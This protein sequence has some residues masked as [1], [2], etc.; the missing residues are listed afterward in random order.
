MRSVIKFIHELYIKRT[1]LCCILVAFAVLLIDYIT[2]RHIEFPIAYALPVGM[3]AWRQKRG[4]AYAMA[5]LLPMVRVGFYFPWNA[6]QFIYTALLNAPVTVLVLMIY[7]YL[8]DRTAWQTEELEKEI[9]ILE[10]ILPICASCKKIRNEAGEYE[11]I[12]KYVTEHSQASFSHGICPECAK[13][14]YPDYV[15]H[16]NNQ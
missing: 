8:I 7:A 15:K 11:Q 14:L 16:K 3:S 4:L 12:E 6:I 13:I 10:G 2:G 9:K 5:I 1:V